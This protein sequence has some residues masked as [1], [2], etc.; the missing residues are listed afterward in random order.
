MVLGCSA[1][2]MHQPFPSALC[3]LPSALCPLPYNQRY[4]L[5]LKNMTH[6]DVMFLLLATAA[7]FVWRA[8]RVSSQVTQGREQA[9]EWRYALMS[10]GTLTIAILLANSM[11]FAK[12][13]M[14]APWMEEQPPTFWEL[15]GPQLSVVAGTASLM[16]LAVRA[17]RHP[18]VFEEPTPELGMSRA[19]LV[20]V[21][22]L[23]PRFWMAVLGLGVVFGLFGGRGMVMLL[24][25]ELTLCWVMGRVLLARARR[26]HSQQK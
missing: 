1:L 7:F 19:V 15:L 3:P 26:K 20:I 14:I 11:A 4:R 5:D 12:E 10:A 24:A 22:R 18:S 17:L 6:R 25:I 9:R 23:L 13:A 2:V 16:W 21:E 8:C